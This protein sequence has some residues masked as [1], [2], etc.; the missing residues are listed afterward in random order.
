TRDDN[1]YAG[2]ITGDLFV[3]CPI[4]PLS[5]LGTVHKVYGKF[6]A[7]GK[8]YFFVHRTNQ[9]GKLVLDSPFHHH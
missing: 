2:Q 1:L 8:M 4:T 3:K 9:E 7:D 6:R 5:G